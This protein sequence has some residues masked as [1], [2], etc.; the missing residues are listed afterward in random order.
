MWT[1]LGYALLVV[2]FLTSLCLR[3]SSSPF[4]RRALT[5]SAYIFVIAL[6]HSVEG[7][8]NAP[9]FLALVLATLALVECI[10]RP[11]VRRRI[12]PPCVR[13][14]ES[15]KA[16]IIGIVAWLCLSILIIY[17]AV[18]TE[19][20][21][22]SVVSLLLITGFAVLLWRE[23]AEI[24]AA[25]IWRWWAFHKW[26]EYKSY[27]LTTKD[28]NVVVELKPGEKS[29]GSERL[30]VR[31]I[32]PP[33]DRET[34]QRLLEANLP[35]LSATVKKI[36]GTKMRTIADYVR[37]VCSFLSLQSL[38]IAWRAARRRRAWVWAAFALPLGWIALHKDMDIL[39]GLC[40]AFLGLAALIA[41]L[42]Q[43][44]RVKSPFVRVNDFGLGKAALV[45]SFAATAGFFLLI[46]LCANSR[47]FP[48]V[49]AFLIAALCC[50]FIIIVLR[51]RSKI[52]GNGIW[53]H[54]M[55]QTWDM[56]DSFSWT[57][58]DKNSAVVELK[59]P[60]ITPLLF[61]N[62]LRLTVPPES[63][64]EAKQLL[65]ANLPDAGATRLNA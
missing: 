27:S 61:C 25:G 59:R 64:E 41:Y 26:D 17:L 14:K 31:F 2:F 3:L 16:D 29:W 39:V 22:A 45:I 53:H 37:L 49:I 28:E 60:G 6:I 51:E 5:W 24:C 13:V 56:F 20:V 23:T 40:F 34:V 62:S 15:S 21:F 1:P 52:C 9:I 4:A 11:I 8:Q 12:V 19:L 55:P 63:L 7:I 10:A 54:G 32:V 47:A 57:W 46:G 43:K 36:K 48:G 38:K 33:E 35:E 42:I 50:A 58:K 18:V 44:R 30:S 65:E